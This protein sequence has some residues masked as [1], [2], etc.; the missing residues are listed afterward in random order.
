MALACYSAVQPISAIIH[1][2]NHGH[3]ASAPLTGTELLDNQT[4][5]SLANECKQR[6][7]ESSDITYPGRAGRGGQSGKQDL[8]NSE[9][10]QSQPASLDSCHNPLGLTEELQAHVSVRSFPGTDQ[11]AAGVFA[12]QLLWPMTCE[13]I[14]HQRFHECSA[15]LRAAAGPRQ[16]GHVARPS[17]TISK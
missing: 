9:V 3:L 8:G 16:D 11:G 14:E 6:A 12:T 5:L 15:Q 2:C 4:I 10:Y 13:L 1:L 17:R 7:G